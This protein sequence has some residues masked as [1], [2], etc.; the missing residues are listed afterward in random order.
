MTG[1]TGPIF[2]R[3]RDGFTLVEVMITILLIGIVSAFAVSRL[4]SSDTFN[5]S[6]TRDAIISSARSA[7]QKA[8]GRSAVVLTLTPS[9]DTLEMEIED[10]NGNVQSSSA[11]IGD[12]VLSGDVNELDSCSVTPGGEAITASSPMVIGFDALGNLEEGG[13]QGA[14]GYPET[15]S[16]GMRICI[17]NDPA[18]S[19]CLSAA[20]YAYAGDC[21]P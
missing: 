2:R 10:E 16:G 4:I 15:V 18:S 19:L 21:D 8:I 12:L 13:V 11:P 3:P 17:N 1:H 9:G 5:A 7:Q 20:G 14:P 6:I